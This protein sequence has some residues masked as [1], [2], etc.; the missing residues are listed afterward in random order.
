M[1]HDFL[2]AHH[3]EL[4]RR[5]Q[6]KVSLRDVPAAAASDP[7]RGVALFL[8]QLGEALRLRQAN[9]ALPAARASMEGNR[10]ATLHGR[11]MQE[12]GYRVDQVVHDYGDVC[13]AVTE[14]AR[15]R[16]V[17][18]TVDEFQI[19]NRMLDNAI[20]DAVSSYEDH[21]DRSISSHGNVDLHQRLGALAE[22]QRRLLYTALTALEALKVGNIGLLGAT[23]TVL[24]DSLIKL[25]DLIDR[26]HPAL[27][28]STG[29]AKPPQA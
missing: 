29:M 15:E 25:R 19:L 14:L 12:E 8:E 9:G 21:R 27:R 1:L 5:C 16:R 17:P 6:A 4:I 2:S 22:E 20:A 24:E 18:I 28:L 3:D 26:E 7:K 11:Q 13:Q 23:G 10:T